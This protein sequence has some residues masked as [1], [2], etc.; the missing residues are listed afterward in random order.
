MAW[1]DHFAQGLLSWL[2]I[3]HPYDWFVGWLGRIIL[4]KVCFRFFSFSTHMIALLD[5]L[6]GS[7]CKGFAL[8]VFHFSP[9]WLVCWMAWPDHFAQGFL[10]S[11]FIFHPHDWFVGWLGR[12]ILQKV[13]FRF[14]SFS[15]HMIALLDGLAGSFC[16]GFA[17]VA[18][19]FS[20]TWLIFWMAWPD[21]SAKGLLSFPFLSPTWLLCW[22][23]W[24]DHFCWV[25]SNVCS[26]ISQMI[27]VSISSTCPSFHSSPR[28][29]FSGR[30]VGPLSIVWASM[31]FANVC[32]RADCTA[33]SHARM[34]FRDVYVCAFSLC[35][36][37]GVQCWI[38]W[39]DAFSL[40]LHCFC[41]FVCHFGS[42]WNG[43]SLAGFGREGTGMARQSYPFLVLFG[44]PWDPL[45]WLPGS[46]SGA[47]E[48]SMN[49][50]RRLKA[51]QWQ[52]GHFG[53][54]AGFAGWFGRNTVF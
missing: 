6:A 23:D 4:Q 36:R 28:R 54:F 37:H 34:I 16:N 33:G 9:T 51:V 19:H 38:H 52:N 30:L 3:L 18:F 15:T 35:L 39:P 8:V 22:M 45:A 40:G 27:A 46:V 13:C 41:S 20:P 17:L 1:P 50:A 14:F 25:C 10:S 21:Q 29:S 42:S 49:S 5:G 12:I 48:F 7:F 43:T 26:C 32:F 47:V 31:C 24:L 2:F 53:V 44:Y 11:L